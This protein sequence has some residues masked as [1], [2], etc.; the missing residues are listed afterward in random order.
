VGGRH[1][2]VE[3]RIAAPASDIWA[4]IRDVAAVNTRLAPGFVAAAHLEI[5][6]RTVT[7]ANG[8][9][10]KET[11]ISIDDD[12]NHRVGYSATGGRSTFHFA[13]M[14]V[15]PDGDGSRL[16]WITDAARSAPHDCCSK[17]AVC[18]RHYKLM[19]V[20]HY[21]VRDAML[22]S[23]GYPWTVIRVEDRQD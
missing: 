6:V 3:T 23:G 17:S 1:Q 8:L 11:I 16:I 18:G 15:V 14:Q 2:H 9:T 5:G 4:A 22:A 21:A 20:R 19:K 12:N 10:V 7:F 13:S